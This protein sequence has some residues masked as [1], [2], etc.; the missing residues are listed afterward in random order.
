MRFWLL[1]RRPAEAGRYFSRRIWK[2][3]HAGQEGGG[4]AVRE[5]Q[6][7]VFERIWAEVPS[8]ILS[9]GSQARLELSSGICLQAS[10]REPY[11]PC[12]DPEW[13]VPTGGVVDHFYGLPIKF[14]SACH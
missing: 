2:I 6:E 13:F 8:P 14:Q 11:K 4:E 5:R 10:S 7:G 9:H 3:L 1:E 12:Y